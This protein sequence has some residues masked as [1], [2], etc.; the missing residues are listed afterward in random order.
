MIYD[1][2]QY[3]A[4]LAK[5]IDESRGQKFVI[6]VHSTG[7]IHTERLVQAVHDKSKVRLVLLDP[8]ARS[9]RENYF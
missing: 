9:D 6:A 4:C 3:V 8:R 2:R 5:Q 7:A 1:G